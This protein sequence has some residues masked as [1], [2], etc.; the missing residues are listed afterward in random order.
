M[1]LLRGQCYTL[2]LILYF[3]KAIKEFDHHKA[4]KESKLGLIIFFFLSIKKEKKKPNKISQVISF[5][6]HL[7]F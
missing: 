6:E 5:S 1:G 2:K 4:I 3:H 7:S